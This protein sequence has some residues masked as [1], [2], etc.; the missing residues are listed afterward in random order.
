MDLVGG[1]LYGH[2][3]VAYTMQWRV[4]LVCMVRYG[5]QHVGVCILMCM[6]ICV[7]VVCVAGNTQCMQWDV[8]AISEITKAVVVISDQHI[9]RCAVAVV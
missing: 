8:V 4:C 1:A 7:H 2:K 9:A 6:C 5:A 3:G